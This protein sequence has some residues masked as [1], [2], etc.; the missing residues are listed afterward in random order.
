MDLRTRDGQTLL[1]LA[2]NGHTPVDDF[3]TNDVCKFPCID[4][5]KL[6]LC[7]DPAMIFQVDH[8]FNTPLHTLISNVSTS[9]GCP[10]LVIVAIIM[11]VILFA[12][13]HASSG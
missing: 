2:V 3:H 6:L 12:G 4:T 7:C 9:L 10:V 11:R 13:I 5:V 8:Q 1:H